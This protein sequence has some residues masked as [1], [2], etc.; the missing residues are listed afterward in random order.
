M[1]KGLKYHVLKRPNDDGV[2]IC[3]RTWNLTS[4]QCVTAQVNIS[5]WIQ[6]VQ[7]LNRH[8]CSDGYSWV[9]KKKKKT[10]NTE[11]IIAYGS[12]FV[13]NSSM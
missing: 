12:G 4:T 3:A 6:I 10:K 2:R 8:T 7:E 9:K 13:D 11:T 1:P 5:C